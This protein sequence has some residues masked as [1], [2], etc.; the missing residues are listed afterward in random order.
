M[1]IRLKFFFNSRSNAK[2]TILS[3]EFAIKHLFQVLYFVTINS[4]LMKNN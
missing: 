2:L 3:K 4:F 1:Q